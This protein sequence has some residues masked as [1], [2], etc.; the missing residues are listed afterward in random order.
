MLS[1]PPPPPAVEVIVENTE[2]LPLLPLL[3]PDVEPEPPAPTV[4][5]QAKVQTQVIKDP[6]AGQ[7]DFRK[8]DFDLKK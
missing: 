1:E 6:Y 3:A 5:E 7:Q 2:L 8:A 4:T